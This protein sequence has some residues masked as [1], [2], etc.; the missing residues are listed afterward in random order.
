MVALGCVVAPNNAEFAKPPSN[1]DNNKLHANDKAVGTFTTQDIIK[2]LSRTTTGARLVT[3]ADKKGAYEV[4][5]IDGVNSEFRRPNSYNGL[6]RPTLFVGRDQ[7]L[8]QAIEYAEHE[9][10][11]YLD[12]RNWPRDSGND[13]VARESRA[14]KIQA[15]IYNKLRSLHPGYTDMTSDYLND[16][17]ADGEIE[18]F[19]RRAYKTTIEALD[20]K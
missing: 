7:S 20:Q 8:L 13:L 9:I 2:G 14:F 11:H 18:E 15:R 3:L 4:E 6:K 19:I 10:L 1:S 17:I 16:L 5:F 12:T